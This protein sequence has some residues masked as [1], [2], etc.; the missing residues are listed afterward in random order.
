M[1]TL[2]LV[3][4]TLSARCTFFELM[5]R[6]EAL[7][8]RHG[9]RAT[10]KRR[11]PKWLRIEQPAAMHF[12]GT[13]VERVHAELPQFAE[14]GDGAQVTVIQRHFG[15]FAPY[16]PLPLH[17]TEHAMQEKR[18][19]RNAAFERFINVAC[20]ELAWLHYTAWSS[21]HPVLGYE[22]VRHP[23]VERVTAL[24]DARRASTADAEPFADHALACRRA[25]PGLYCAPRRSLADLQR[26]LAAYFGVPLR[27]VPRHG[28][29]IP[30][31]A[32][33]SEARR[34]GGW[35]L[36]ARIWD[37]Q[38]SAEIVI[39]PLEAD[40]FQRWQRRAAAVLAMSAVVTDFVDGRIDPVIKVQVRT[41]PE[42]AGR[43]G[44]MR[45]GVDAWS[46]PDCALRTLTVYESFRD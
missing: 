24:A 45:V 46:R 26:M 41:R 33:A 5:R 17:V 25:F 44:R 42:L 3:T 1:K 14:D 40:G 15:L 28:R 35:R 10:R 20:G 13:E 18:F 39:G 2:E 9:T 27:V 4:R 7:Q 31:A 21:M 16:G 11:V 12:A 34:L 43:I 6:V 8:R 29:W 19:E 22:R 37:V 30:V 32:A 36:G 38:Y 23:F